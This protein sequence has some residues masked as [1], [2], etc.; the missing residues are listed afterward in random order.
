MGEF[1]GK[2]PVKEVG[3]TI[4]ANIPERRQ[5]D[6]T[7]QIEA[8]Q[9]PGLKEAAKAARRIADQGQEPSAPKEKSPW[10]RAVEA[11]RK[12]VSRKSDKDSPEKK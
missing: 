6:R 11:L 3:I 10:V 12:K 4:E 7:Q 2:P 9:D 8:I 1:E 5:G